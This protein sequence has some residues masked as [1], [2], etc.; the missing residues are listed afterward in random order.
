LESGGFQAFAEFGEVFHH[1]GVNF[2]AFIAQRQTPHTTVRF[3]ENLFDPTPATACF[4]EL[5]ND[6]GYRLGG[7]PGPLSD[8]DLGGAVIGGDAP[9]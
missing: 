9:E 1:P 2:P 4:T 7:K 5:G 3:I 8:L 6:P